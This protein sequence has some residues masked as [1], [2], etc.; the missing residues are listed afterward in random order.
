MVQRR[1]IQP[2]QE[3]DELQR[4]SRQRLYERASSR[5]PCVFGAPDRESRRDRPGDSSRTARACLAN[6]RSNGMLNNG[7]GTWRACRGAMRADRARWPARSSKSLG[8]GRPGAGGFDSHPPSP[9]SHPWHHVDSFRCFLV[10]VFSKDA[11]AHKTAKRQSQQ[12]RAPVRTCARTRRKT[13]FLVES[14][15]QSWA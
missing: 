9:A 8:V 12:Q 4:E 15:K 3:R 14:S 5:P 1:S 7:H 2:S 13:R 6:V 10:A 11:G